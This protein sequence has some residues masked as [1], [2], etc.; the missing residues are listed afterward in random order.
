MRC[1]GDNDKDN[2]NDQPGTLLLPL[3]AGRIRNDALTY[4]HLWQIQTT[5]LNAGK[6]LYLSYC[7]LSRT[8][9][10]LNHHSD[11]SMCCDSY[12][13]GD[14]ISRFDIHSLNWIIYVHFFSFFGVQLF[15]QTY[16]FLCPRAFLIYA[17]SPV[18]S[19]VFFLYTETESYVVVIPNERAQLRSCF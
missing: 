2:E 1:H 17:I 16:L 18:L 11:W 4:A 10:S 5:V 8:P 13:T 19:E 6:P 3:I 14:H 9:S 15:F 7:T 12:R